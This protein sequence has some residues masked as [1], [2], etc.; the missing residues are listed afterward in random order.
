[1]K[2]DGISFKLEVFCVMY[3]D[4]SIDFTVNC[5][6]SD[7]NGIASGTMTC[8]TLAMKPVPLLQGTGFYAFFGEFR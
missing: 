2:V 1:M 7:L 8:P 4:I 6:Y 3:N 5:P